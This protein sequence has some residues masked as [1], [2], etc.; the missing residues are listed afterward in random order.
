M[1]IITRLLMLTTFTY[2][3]IL[4]R[5]GVLLLKRVIVDHVFMV[6]SLLISF[7]ILQILA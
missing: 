2:I 7:F 1:L 5:Y 4:I 6:K 3:G